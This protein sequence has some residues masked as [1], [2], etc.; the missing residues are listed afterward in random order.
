MDCDGDAVDDLNT[1]FIRKSVRWEDQQQGRGVDNYTDLDSDLE[2]EK[3]L[4]VDAS[5]ES[6]DF[7][8]GFSDSSTEE[9]RFEAV[10][11]GP[12]KIEAKSQQ[13]NAKDGQ[14]PVAGDKDCAEVVH[15]YDAFSSED[16]DNET[17]GVMGGFG[18][19]QIRKP[20]TTH[21]SPADRLHLAVWK[22]NPDLV[23]HLVFRQGVFIDC[24]NVMGQTPLFVAAYT[25]SGH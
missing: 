1:G 5:N 24:F 19:V 10:D 13:T 12:T 14:L 3:T 8:A 7:S 21:K 18:P 2:D 25:R 4:V 20:R 11:G 23:H 22:N 9:E 15:H 16:D 17:D 6:S